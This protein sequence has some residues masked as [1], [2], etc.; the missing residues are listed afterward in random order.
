MTRWL[1]VD[2]GLTGAVALFDDETKALVVRDLPTFVTKHAKNKTK[3]SLDLSGVLELIR[4]LNPT[5][6]I[7]EDVHAMPGQG[8]VGVARF[9]RC[10]GQLDMALAA[11][12]VPAT[13]VSP[14]V[15]KRALQVRGEKD[16][17]RQR[18]LQLF[19]DQASVFSR[20]SDHNR[21]DAAL[22]AFFGAA[23]LDSPF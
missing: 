4:T 11:L 3:T 12:R 22:I 13:Y 10:A 8:V 18:A 2:P 15:W 6:A 23:H 21:A 7:M 9:M 5:H 17:G 1:G 14:V 16:D 19:P 20:K